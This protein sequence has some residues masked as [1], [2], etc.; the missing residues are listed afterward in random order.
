VK[1]FMVIGL[2]NFG[3]EVV[4]TLFELG[5]EVVAIDKSRERVQ[6]ISEFSSRAIIADAE[7]KDFLLNTGALEMD[8]VVL[9]MGNNISQSIIATLFLKELGVPYV[10]VK[11]NDPDH[12]RALEKIGAD[13]IIYPEQEVA[14]KLSR[15]LTEPSVIDFY[16]LSRDYLMTKLLAP[17]DLVGKNLLESELREKYDVFVI[18]V[19]EAVPDNFLIL[20]G[21][22]YRIKDSDVLVILGKATDIERLEK[23]V[24]DSNG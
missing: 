15:Q 23:N 20:P 17:L 1:K 3:S 10:V 8:A 21:A 18:A 9:S 11:A 16:D 2:G 14:V 4:K 13:R 5:N 12:G 22:D 6:Q 7:D 19:K 24:R